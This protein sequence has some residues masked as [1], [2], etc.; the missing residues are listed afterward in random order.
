MSKLG[1]EE[2]LVK[3]SIVIWIGLF[4]NVAL[5]ILKFIVGVISNSSALIADAIHSLSDF[6]SDISILIGLKIAAKP[7]DQDHNYGHGKFETLSAIIIGITLFIVGVGIL[8]N[9]VTIIFNYLNGESLIRPGIIAI[10][11]LIAS[12]LIKEGLYHYTVRSGKTLHSQVLIA[13][14]WHHR[15]DA[16]SSIAVLI[17]V[18]GAI[19]LGDRWVIL[20]PISAAIVSI[21]ILR[22]AAKTSI[23]SFHELMEVSLSKERQKEILA[24]VTEV[25]GANIP[26]NLK[27]RKIGNTVAIDLHIK[28]N[29]DL[30]IVEAHDIATMVEDKLK[31]TFGGETFTSVHVEPL[32]EESSV[33]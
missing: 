2:R 20:D 25:P 21:F 23:D 17:G 31:N 30:S 5:T 33:K 14:A 6:A 26:H 27:T 16:L 12:I 18:S 9:S 15:S 1:N 3:S 19:V 28:V 7:V 11:A 8:W 24:I 10:Y 22:V 29:K 13:N 32:L 4:W